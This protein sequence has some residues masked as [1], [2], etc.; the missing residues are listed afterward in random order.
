[1]GTRIKVPAGKACFWDVN[2]W[3]NGSFYNKVRLKV[4]VGHVGYGYSKGLGS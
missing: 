1:M 4:K 3:L 2:T